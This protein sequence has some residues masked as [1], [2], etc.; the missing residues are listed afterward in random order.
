MNQKMKSLMNKLLTKETI[1]IL[2]FIVV[3][4]LTIK[5][6][7]P[8]AYIILPTVVLWYMAIEMMKKEENQ[9][10][11]KI[12]NALPIFWGVQSLLDVSLFYFF[13]FSWMF[14]TLNQN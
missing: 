12:F 1:W 7:F 8:V 10:Y 9:R 6:M 13:E 2:L 4:L 11:E 14:Y 5:F 3:A